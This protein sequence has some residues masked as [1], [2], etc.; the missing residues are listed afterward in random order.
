MPTAL[1]SRLCYLVGEIKRPVIVL[2]GEANQARSGFSSLIHGSQTVLV[3]S[4]SGPA[5]PLRV[6]NAPS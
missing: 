5:L 3:S 1:H 6:A 2:F 4:A